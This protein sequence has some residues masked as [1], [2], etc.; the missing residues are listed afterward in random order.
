M[1]LGLPF[2]VTGIGGP[3]AD[4]EQRLVQVIRDGPVRHA[5]ALHDRADGRDRVG[6]Q[7]GDKPAEAGKSHHLG[8][9]VVTDGG[10]PGGDGARPRVGMRHTDW[11][12][13]N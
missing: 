13:S 10:P 12:S 6:R 9:Q 3:A 11:P 2:Q 5:L 4:I 1:Q 7:F 8:V